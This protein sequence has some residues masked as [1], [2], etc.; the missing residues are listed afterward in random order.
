MGRSIC[1]WVEGR[2]EEGWFWTTGLSTGWLSNSFLWPSPEFSPP[3]NAWGTQ[4]HLWVAVCLWQA[5]QTERSKSK[6]CLA[7]SNC[8]L[9]ERVSFAPIAKTGCFTH[10]INHCFFEFS[11]GCFHFFSSCQKAKGASYH[12]KYVHLLSISHRC[13]QDSAWAML[14]SSPPFFKRHPAWWTVL[15]HSNACTLLCVILVDPNE[16]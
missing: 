12:F 7:F 9:T 15:E 4:T 13:L 10:L 14:F 8:P 3:W 16:R 5:A 1:A 6:R 11:E 2:G